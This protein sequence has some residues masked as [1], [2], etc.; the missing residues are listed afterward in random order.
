[1]LLRF[2]IL[3][4]C[5]IV[6]LFTKSQLLRKFSLIALFFGRFSMV[7]ADAGTPSRN[8]VQG[9]SVKKKQILNFSSFFPSKNFQITLCAVLFEERT[10]LS[11]HFRRN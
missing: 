6:G 2:S 1:M 10:R 3:L 4:H 5:V 9:E 8:D 11:K 7:K